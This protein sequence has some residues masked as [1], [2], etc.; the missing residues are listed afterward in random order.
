MI[1]DARK[2]ETWKSFAME[3]SC[4][5]S[6]ADLG[7]LLVRFC[8]VSLKLKFNAMHK[9]V[10]NIDLVISLCCQHLLVDDTPRLHK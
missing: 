8:N 4:C 1:E 5:K 9:F 6:Y 10:K 3:A 2:T 7:E